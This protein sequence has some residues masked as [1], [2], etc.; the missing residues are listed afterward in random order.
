MHSCRT[1]VPVYSI[2]RITS[3]QRPRITPQP[4]MDMS[5]G[6]AIWQKKISDSLAVEVQ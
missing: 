4:S 6:F 5:R 2:N 3:L 1:G